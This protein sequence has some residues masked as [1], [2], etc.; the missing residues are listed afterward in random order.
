MKLKEILDKAGIMP[1]QTKELK[2]S[3]TEQG[4]GYDNAV[5]RISEIE[6]NDYIKEG[7]MK[8]KQSEMYREC[9][10]CHGTGTYLRDIEGDDDCCTCRF[11]MVKC[12]K[13]KE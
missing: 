13:C 2:K 1:V 8:E 10:K 3:L 11:E 6:L 5:K 4:V 7:K 9:K 12:D